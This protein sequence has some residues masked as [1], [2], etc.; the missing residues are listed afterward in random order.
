MRPRPIRDISL[1]PDEIG[2]DSFLDTIANLVGVLIILVV[3]VGANAKSTPVSSN[4]CSEQKSQIAEIRQ[5][6][7]QNEQTDQNIRAEYSDL[8]R[9]IANEESL[10]EVKSIERRQILTVLTQLNNELEEQEATLDQAKRDSLAR[11]N[12]R[13]ILQQRLNDLEEHFSAIENHAPQVQAIDHYPTPIVKTVFRDDVHFRLKGGRLAFVPM[14]EL[15]QL[16]RAEWELKAEKLASAPRVVEAVGPTNGFRLQYEL[17]ARRVMQ[18]TSVG[19]VSGRSIEFDHFVVMPL[20]ET[21]GEALDDALQSDSGFSARIQRL[22]PEQ[23]T[24]SVWVY[25]DSYEEFNDL[26]H[27]LYDR[28]FQTAAWPLSEGALISGGPNGFRATAQ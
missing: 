26:K 3:M 19:P 12:Q 2:Q 17:V 5:A 18:Q 22:K 11:N 20:S 1:L 27:W 13:Q 7:Q 10:L 15:L 9:Q 6:V 23:H 14:D 4:A 28:G 21:I 16:M 25:P 8:Q 24:I